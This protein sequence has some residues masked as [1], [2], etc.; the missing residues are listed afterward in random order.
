MG[1]YRSATQPHNPGDTH[2]T[3]L[4]RI[5][6]PSQHYQ[7]LTMSSSEQMSLARSR[8]VGADPQIRIHDRW[9]YA[10][11]CATVY[12]ANVEKSRSLDDI[13]QV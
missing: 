8:S 9:I 11:F 1:A 7:S 5:K 4:P 13:Y 2:T 3:N 10:G 6:A 12:R